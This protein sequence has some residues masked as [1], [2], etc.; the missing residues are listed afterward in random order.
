MA[1]N[2]DAHVKQPVARLL[3]REKNA[4]H[5]RYLANEKNSDRNNTGDKKMKAS[6]K[7]KL[8]VT[9]VTLALAL[10]SVSVFTGTASAALVNTQMGNFS[11]TYDNVTSTVYNVNY[12]NTN[13]TLNVANSIA[14]SGLNAPISAVSHLDVSKTLQLTNVTLFSTED[15]DMLLLSTTNSSPAQIPS[16]TV[17]LPSVATQVSLTTQQKTAIEDSSN[18]LMATFLPNSIYRI[19]VTDGYVYYFSNSPSSL[20]NGAKTIVFQN[21]SFIPGTS[22]VV[23]TTPSGTIKYSLDKQKNNFNLSL[24][25]LTY[26]PT[27]GDVTGTYLSLNFNSATGIISDY[28][29]K[30]TNTKIFDQI[31]TT[32]NGSIGGGFISP[33]FPGINPLMI[34][35]VF[36]Y[37]NNTAVYQVHNNLATVGNF[38]ISN[39]TTVFKVASNL[40]VS[41]F[42]PSQNAIGQKHMYGYN[43]SN[44]SNLNLG[45]QFM[46]QAAP[47]IIMISND[48]FRGELFVHDG[49]VSVS[50]KTVSVTTS[51]IAHVTFVAQ[52]WFLQ[53]QLQVR[54]QL[55]Y[56]IQH[57]MLGAM[58]SVGPDGH[59]GNNMTT[60][61]NSSMQLRV[62][63]A[64]TN[65]VQIQLESRMQ[66]G[67]N[68]AVFIP[69]EIIK[70]TSQFT[71][72]YDNQEMNM[73]TNMNSVMNSTNQ[74]QAS[75]YMTQVN[76][77][78]LVVINVPHF[79]THSLEI[80]AT[81]AGGMDNLWLYVIITVVVV[82]A[83]GIAAFVII[84]RG[85]RG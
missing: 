26:D 24:D 33:L 36:Y 45:S 41:T 32:G 67:T 64:E 21:S 59:T 47:T 40:N 78:T 60:F 66:H 81:S 75:Y 43:Y 79:T 44:F 8:L 3:R 48:N 71:F 31:Y 80:T 70:N 58:V 16:I 39:G 63:N 57:G 1:L 55:Q 77:G 30:Y 52:V 73:L 68:F 74:N 38:F 28:T 34:G 10:S 19:T 83:A 6:S 11:L 12:S 17:N 61:Y 23:G 62:Q 51:S 9:A 7:G 53:T 49:V 85:R 50:G 65:R 13:Y 35:S 69:N 72:R 5:I 20:T 22:L 25:P 4:E 18:P 42:N 56:A 46:V 54:N 29:N 2:S 15:K 82:A 76:G 37:A 27:T 14:T 84:R